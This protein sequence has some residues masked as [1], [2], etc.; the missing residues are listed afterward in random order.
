MTID[1]QLQ[2]EENSAVNLSLTRLPYPY[3]EGMQLG[4]DIEIIKPMPDYTTKRLTF[5]TIDPST[6]VVWV[7]R[8]IVG[9]WDLPSAEVPDITRGLDDGSYDVRGR[10]MARD[11][12]FEGSILTPDPNKTFAARTKLMEVFDLVYTG[13]WLFVKESPVKAAYVRLVGKPTIRSINARGR[14]DFTF[15][16]RVA[17]PIK[18]SWYDA[19]S[20]NYSA[21]PVNYIPS[22][23]RDDEIVGYT[24]VSI[25]SEG[26]IETYLEN[27][28][29]T[30]VACI[31]K[32]SGPMS[33][34]AFISNLT[35]GET[36]KIIKDLRAGSS[37]PSYS[38]SAYKSLL[39]TNKQCLNGVATLSIADHQ[40]VT[41]DVVTIASISGYNQTSVVLSSTSDST[42]SYLNPLQSIV[43]ITRPSTNTYEITTSGAHGI[44]ATGT[45]FYIGGS[46]NPIFDGVYS[47]TNIPS[48][49]KIRF[50][51]TST[52]SGATAGGSI[53]L[54]LVSAVNSTGSVTLV[55][56]DTIEIDTYNTT[57]LYRG[58]PDNSRSCLDADID[59][60]KLRGGVNVFSAS[61][62][63]PVG[64]T[65]SISAK[66]RSGWIG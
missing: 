59:W 46:T 37:D 6:G 3:V 62:S 17:D 47:V 55:N 10:W 28:G 66:F 43:S 25:G 15:T 63:S 53:S 50:A 24:E 2:S 40:F 32:I 33:Q 8:D 11:L 38:S 14:L 51:K 39:I 22:P 61:H 16:L 57:V 23:D 49:T 20:G 12:T 7:C 26:G 64:T 19:S 34:P 9:W 58:L 42:I 65:P 31:F 18:Y 44:S 56:T 45:S 27:L 29:N 60:I 30:P 21:W 54:E 48:T 36:I 35:T 5:N 1:P 41:G 4:S 13:G 52:T